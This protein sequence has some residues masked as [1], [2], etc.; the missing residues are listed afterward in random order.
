VNCIECGRASYYRLCSRCQDMYDREA[1][2]EA[3]A[4]ARAED[5]DSDRD[6]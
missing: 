4:L 1:E 3:K 6:Y 5:Y 2:R